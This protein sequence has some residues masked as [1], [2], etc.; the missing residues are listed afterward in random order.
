MYSV[1]GAHYRANYNTIG[2]TFHL[3]GD[4]NTTSYNYLKSEPNL[5]TSYNP[6]II[7]GNTTMFGCKDLLAEPGILRTRAGV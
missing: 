3:F 4:S 2:T 7:Q 5:N 1:G 6:F